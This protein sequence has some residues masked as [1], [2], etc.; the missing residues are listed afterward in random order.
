M[1][2]IKPPEAF[3][4]K[5]VALATFATVNMSQRIRL[6][7]LNVVLLPGGILPFRH[8]QGSNFGFSYN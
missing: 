4:E 8:P 3:R 1:A 6:F 7:L 2:R 5:G